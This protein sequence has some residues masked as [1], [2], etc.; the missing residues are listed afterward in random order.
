MQLHH[1]L[2]KQLVIL[3]KETL[4]RCI[5]LHAQSVDYVHAG[6]MRP[7]SIRIMQYKSAD[8]REFTLR[9]IFDMTFNNIYLI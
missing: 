3:T 8:T 5:F 6:S 4:Y 2:R 7:Q 1:Q 9:V